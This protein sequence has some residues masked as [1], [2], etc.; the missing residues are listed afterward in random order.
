MSGR[1]GQVRILTEARLDELMLER[2]L[3]MNWWKLLGMET[4]TEI[5]AGSGGEN[6]NRIRSRKMGESMLET[7][8]FLLQNR[9]WMCT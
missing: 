7:E 2:I 5:E 1:S 4:H 6:R 8:E 9:N 3:V